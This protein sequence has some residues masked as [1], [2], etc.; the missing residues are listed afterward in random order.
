MAATKAHK[1]WLLSVCQNP[2]EPPFVV[3]LSDSGQKHLLYRSKVC[4]SQDVVTVTLESEPITFQPEALAERL[5]LAMQVAAAV[6]KPALVEPLSLNQ[7]MGV[8][9]YH[10]LSVESVLTEWNAVQS[11]P[12]SR[13]ASWF[14][15]AQKE[16]RN[17]YPKVG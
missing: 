11:Q 15:P 16:C 17:D 7:Q 14:C 6:G 9:N 5:R 1:D 3:C 13:L 12:L 4:F 8:L 10:G 2:P